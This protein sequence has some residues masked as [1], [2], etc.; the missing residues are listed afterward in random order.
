L[1]GFFAT[2]VHTAL[3]AL[4]LM[5]VLSLV[6]IVA[7]FRWIMGF[8]HAGTYVVQGA[9]HTAKIRG[10][11]IVHGNL[12]SSAHAAAATLDKMFQGS[13]WYQATG[14]DGDDIVVYTVSTPPAGLVPKD[15]SGHHVR[16]VDMGIVS[17]G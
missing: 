16:V 15:R 11:E 10:N 13:S 12:Y 9:V 14:V 4:I 6:G 2:L 1:E 17:A 5:A 8:I 3:W 7:I